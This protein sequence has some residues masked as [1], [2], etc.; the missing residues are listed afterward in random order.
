MVGLQASARAHSTARR[1]HPNRDL[2]GQETHM[3]PTL[4]PTAQPAHPHRAASAVST[5]APMRPARKRRPRPSR[6]EAVGSPA[7]GMS[8][9][10]KPARRSTAAANRTCTN[11]ETAA[12]KSY[13]LGGYTGSAGRE[14]DLIAV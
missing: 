1:D 4:S 10:P 11:A 9:S 5:L 13:R 14:R 3:S 8:R 2:S 12:N 7:E 6:G